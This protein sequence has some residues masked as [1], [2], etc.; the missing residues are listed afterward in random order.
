MLSLEDKALTPPFRGY[1]MQ[2]WEKLANSPSRQLMMSLKLIDRPSVSLSTLKAAYLALF[3][4]LGPRDG[5][6]YVCGTALAP[7]RQLIAEPLRRDAIQRYVCQVGEETPDRD[8]LLISQPV[9][10]WLV[11][12][13]SQLVNL[14]FAGHSPIS[15]PHWEWH[16]LTGGDS[17][18]ISTHAFWS[19]HTFGALRALHVH[20]TGASKLESLVGFTMSRT[21]PNGQHLEGTCVRH[22]G[23]MAILLCTGAGPPGRRSP[24][25][26]RR[27]ARRFRRLGSGAK[28]LRNAKPHRLGVVKCRDSSV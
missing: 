15:P 19:F 9:P 5:Y 3:S 17:V 27:I 4:L 14:P 1:A 8:I 23:E 7:I 24:S 12:I 10:C 28:T 26:A 11:K 6:G 22:A 2:D 25:Y 18:P 21:L 13:G 16:R 20:L